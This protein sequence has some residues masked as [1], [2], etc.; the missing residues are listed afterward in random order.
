MTDTMQPACAAFAIQ[1]EFNIFTAAETRSCLLEH[2]HAA[3]AP[4][5]E[6]DLS[7]VSEI[8]TAGLQLMI[9]AKREAAALDK[10]LRFVG[11]SAPVLELLDLCD[12]AGFFG[13]P[14]VTAPQPE[15]P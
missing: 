12:L 8:D 13:D 2:I 1:G 10:P 4:D 11:Q 7:Q 6:I 15:A 9:M 3:Q 5:I 14:I